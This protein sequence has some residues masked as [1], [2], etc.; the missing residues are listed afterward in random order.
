M[1]GEAVQKQR[2]MGWV[3]SR[4]ANKV[5]IEQQRAIERLKGTV[6]VLEDKYRDKESYIERLEETLGMKA[7][8]GRGIEDR[9]GG[10]GGDIADQRRW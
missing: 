3:A 4:E 5:M 1:V 6:E 10:R 7:E 8:E 9:E 2:G